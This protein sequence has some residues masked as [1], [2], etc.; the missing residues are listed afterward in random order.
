MKIGIDL[1]GTNIR[2]GLLQEGEIVRKVAA[3]T[4]SKMPLEES[5]A[6]LKSVIA[7]MLS[8]EIE[9][10]GIGVPSVVDVV[11]GI[12]YNVMN[13]PAWEE[14]HLK[15]ILEEAF[16]L[17]VYVNNDANCFALGEKRFG[18]GKPFA[19]MLGLTLGTGVGTG[20]I[21]H[22]ELYNGSNTG[23][24]EIGCIRYL[25][26]VYEYYC[27]SAFFTELHN[28]TGKEAAKRAQNQDMDALRIWD[29]YGRHL[30]ELIK[31]ALF[32]YDPDAIILGGSIA[33]AYPF[34]KTGM[35]ENLQSFPYPKSLERL[36]IGISSN[37]DIAILG[38][39]AL[40]E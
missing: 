23:A 27:G 8:P 25:D 10:I 40:I 24:G 15:K 2:I 31:V 12:V 21:I 35:E 6:Y 22:N 38:A 26:Q 20:V 17:P 39:V 37:P 19:N 16:L 32:A 33:A 13:I 4:P 7:P 9:S 11:Q 3:P 14:V 36:Y 5:I 30:G 34:F 18:E 1:G 28:T 29:E